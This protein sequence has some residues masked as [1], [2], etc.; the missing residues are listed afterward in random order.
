MR[1]GQVLEISRWEYLQ[2][3][4]SKGF[5]ISLILFPVFML[6]L[7][8]L[9]SLLMTAE[10]S[11]VQTIGIV[12]PTGEYAGAITSA[13]ASRG[14]TG[15]GEA[16]WNLRQY[17]PDSSGIAEAHADALAEEIE[18][19]LEVV[20]EGE[21]VTFVWRST[22]LADMQTSQAVQGSVRDVVRSRR[23]REA[24]LDREVAARI[25]GPVEIV[26]RKISEEG[27]SDSDAGMEFMVT[28]FSAFI[29]IMLFMILI[30]TTGQTLV[31]GLVE[32]KSNR[33]MEILVGTTR[34][35]ELM[36]GKLLGLSALGLTQVAAWA[37]LGGGVFLAM[38]GS[39]MMPPELLASAIEPL[40]LVMVYL[41]LG[42]LF[43]AALF[44]GA[45]SLVTTEQEAQYV[46]QYI[47]MMIAAPLAFAVVV[48]QDPNA[49][50]VEA[51]SYVPFL[52]PALMMLRVV[53]ADPG[54][55]TII[56]TVAVLLLSTVAV[57]WVAARIF[58]TAILL[59]GKRPS[60]REVVRWLRE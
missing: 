37:I 21:D 26:T 22:N 54:A 57:T 6:L 38:S 24:G 46:T 10:P 28:F 55:G 18:G 14:E 39:A 48:M 25:T 27:E 52:T 58:R 36:W 59:Y 60:M 40:P 23:I 49:P 2:K 3:V 45:G 8:L 50:W 15:E 43:Y 42:Y 30:L 47:T 32:E 5:I 4:R 34:P 11:T 1:W 53:V 12:D 41:V 56:G 20:E 33:I 35:T 7:G 17:Q 31:R 44:V 9:P 16:I 51:V 29:G 19:F 13:L